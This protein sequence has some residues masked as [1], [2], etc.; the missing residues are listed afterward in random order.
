[1]DYST[2]HQKLL[3]T[4]SGR[5]LFSHLPRG[6]FEKAPTVEAHEALTFFWDSQAA[7]ETDEIELTDFPNLRPPINKMAFIEGKKPVRDLIGKTAGRVGYSRHTCNQAPL[8][9]NV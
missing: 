2:L 9:C 7:P 6:H 1:M 4:G 3:A 5:G 8:A